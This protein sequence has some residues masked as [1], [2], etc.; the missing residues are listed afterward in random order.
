MIPS[1][2]LQLAVSLDSLASFLTGLSDVPCQRITRRLIVASERDSAVPDLVDEP[3]YSL[4]DPG[5]LRPL[6]CEGL[7]NTLRSEQ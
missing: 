1:D 6:P 2:W 3:R 7:C 5:E 4:R